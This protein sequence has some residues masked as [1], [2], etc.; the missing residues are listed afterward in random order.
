MELRQVQS[1]IAIADGGSFSR[2]AIA[3]NLTQPS[4]SRQIALLEE[5]L[6]QRLLVR[7]GRGVQL[8][9]AGEAFPVHAR[10]MLDAARHARDAVQDLGC[11]ERPERPAGLPQ[12]ATASPLQLRLALLAVRAAAWSAR[13]RPF[14]RNTPRTLYRRVR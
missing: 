12:G 9:A 13:V 3:L 6:G 11:P 10:Q 5:E 1:L 7:T 2:A 14:F 4:L 8:T